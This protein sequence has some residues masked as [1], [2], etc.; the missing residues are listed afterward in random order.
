MGS[1]SQHV[2]TSGHASMKQLKQTNVTDVPILDQP[3]GRNRTPHAVAIILF[4]QS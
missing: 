1:K 4:K 2:D 3:A